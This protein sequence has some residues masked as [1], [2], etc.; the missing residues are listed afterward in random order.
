MPSSCEPGP[1]CKTWTFVNRSFQIRK[2]LFSRLHLL[3]VYTIQIKIQGEKQ[4]RQK[5]HALSFHLFYAG[6]VR[7]SLP[8]CLSDDFVWQ[9]EERLAWACNHQV[10][11]HD[12]C[13]RTLPH[14]RTPCGIV[15]CPESYYFITTTDHSHVYGHSW[16]SQ[17]AN[18]CSK[19]STTIMKSAVFREFMGLSPV[20]TN[21]HN[22]INSAFN[23]S[24]LIREAIPLVGKFRCF[25]KFMPPS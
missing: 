15:H 9:E 2:C 11:C 1:P 5:G 7:G 21:Y 23:L 10:L 18:L 16:H 13:L 8:L 14:W 22:C 4:L 24:C 3:G 6:R 19:V 20:R 12:P 17:L 25:S